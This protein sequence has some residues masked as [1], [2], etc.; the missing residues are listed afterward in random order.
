MSEYAIGAATQN[1]EANDMNAGVD[2]QKDPLYTGLNKM[3]QH[4]EQQMTPAER[5]AVIHA[6]GGTPKK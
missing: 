6:F 4:K 5:A 3:R 2:P 1:V